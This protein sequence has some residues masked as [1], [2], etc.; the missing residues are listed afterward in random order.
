MKAERRRRDTREYINDIFSY[1]IMRTPESLK[2]KINMPIGEMLIKYDYNYVG[3][4]NF[5]HSVVLKVDKIMAENP[6][7]VED[8]I[9][10]TRK[11]EII[12]N[13]LEIIMKKD[14]GVTGLMVNDDHYEAIL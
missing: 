1:T 7:M 12:S 6:N 4:Y 5:I 3:A 8:C 9:L 11:M 14:F 2:A 10:F 13:A